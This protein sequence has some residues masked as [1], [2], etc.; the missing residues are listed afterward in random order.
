MDDTA[1]ASDSFIDHVVID[2]VFYSL[3]RY[4]LRMNKRAKKRLQET[5]KKERLE[6][7]KP[8]QEYHP[9][10]AKDDPRQQ[11]GFLPRPDKKR[12]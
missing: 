2:T 11:T 5:I 6:R 8:G 4:N 1:S 3:L 7:A 9:T 10:S 12:G